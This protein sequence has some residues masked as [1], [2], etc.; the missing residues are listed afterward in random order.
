MNQFERIPKVLHINDRQ[1]MDERSYT[2]V[3]EIEYLVDAL[4]TILG[5]HLEMQHYLLENSDYKLAV[6]KGSHI[7]GGL[8]HVNAKYPLLQP[9]YY[10]FPTILISKDLNYF[11]I[12]GPLRY[13]TNHIAFPNLGESKTPD[14]DVQALLI[15]LN[16]SIDP[17][18]FKSGHHLT[19]GQGYLYNEEEVTKYSQKLKRACGINQFDTQQFPWPLIHTSDRGLNSKGF[20]MNEEWQVLVPQPLGVTD[21]H[22]IPVGESPEDLENLGIQIFVNGILYKEFLMK[23]KLAKE[24]DIQLKNKD[25]EKKVTAKVYRSDGVVEINWT[26]NLGNQINFFWPGKTEEAR[27]LDIIKSYGWSDEKRFE[28]VKRNIE[29]IG[30]STNSHY[31]DFAAKGLKTSP[32]SNL[33]SIAIEPSD[34]PQTVN[35]FRKGNIW[36]GNRRIRKE[37]G[38]RGN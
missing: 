1:P 37:I 15:Q 4:S 6:A 24:F 35:N 38:F 19:G 11:S 28:S 8:E 3:F 27:S 13:R 20:Y 31:D 29:N 36:N 14:F 21:H 23:E 26:G 18:H 17:N 12:I 30:I 33:F 5:P 32:N 22:Y 10:A 25:K 7:I 16:P 2:Q 34:E 9:S